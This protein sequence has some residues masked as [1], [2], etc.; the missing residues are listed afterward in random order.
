MKAR[1]HIP[2]K[3]LKVFVSCNIAKPLNGAV[4][5]SNIA[6]LLRL[7]PV[8]YTYKGGKQEKK[9]TVQTYHIKG[10]RGALR[11]A[12][13]E[14]CHAAGLEICHT[15]DKE[16]TKDGQSLLPAGFHLL[17]ACGKNGDRCVVNE[18]FGSMNRESRITV[19][20]DPIGSIP[21]KTSVAN[22]IQNVH[23][24]TENRICK[25]FDG[26]VAQDF[27]ERYFSGAFTFEI[28]LTHC[29]SLQQ[30]LLIQ[31]AMA[32]KRLGGGY[33][34][35]Y[36]RLTVQQFQYLK[37]ITKRVPIW[38]E[39]TFKVNEEVIEESLKDEPLAALQAWEDYLATRS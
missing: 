15:T 32:L 28:N 13:M 1:T 19:Y 36:G 14:I 4:P 18:L 31:A 37:R 2:E 30:G 16:A 21:H 25:T 35:G 20:S 22:G 38:T 26:K 29:T 24:A 6:H 34:A 27:G 9:A 11:H 17:G 39:D 3:I 10:L 12:V 5:R 23:I 33:N 8:S 7:V